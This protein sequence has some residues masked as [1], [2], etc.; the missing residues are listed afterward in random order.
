MTGVVGALVEAWDELRLHKLRVLLSLIGVAVSVAAM[1]AVLAVGQMTAQAQTEMMERDMG[2]QTTLTVNAFAATPSGNSDVVPAMR[3]LAARYQVD[4]ASVVQWASGRFRAGGATFESQLQ[5]VDQPY[6]TMHR[7]QLVDGAW[8]APGDEDRLAPALVV[9]EA[10]LSAVDSPGLATH[11]TVT[12]PGANPVT[13]VVTGVMANRWPD[14]GP[15]AFVLYDSYSRVSGAPEVDPAMGAVPQLEL[16]V[17]PE[18]ADLG[19]E[20][21]RRDLTAALGEGAMVDVYSNAVSG[22]EAFDRTFRLVVLGIG[23]LVLL[24]GALSLVNISLVTVRQRIR[25]IGIRRSFGATSGRVFFSIMLES[26][27]ATAVAG[28]VGVGLAVVAV[29]NLP[30]ESLLGFGLED[31]P[32]FPLAAA[33]TG[34]AAAAGVGALAGLLPAAVAVRVRPI[35]AIR[36]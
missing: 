17:P 36:Y 27:V 19:M 8:F 4:H 23:T 25:E 26:V 24:L 16:W 30:L 11:P 2:R 21:V 14:E 22:Q 29:R 12:L 35:D 9:N 3:E 6:G 7:I 32:P 15:A 28:V 34:L 1:T 10:F 5:L 33:L 20:T 18:T 13:L 31:T